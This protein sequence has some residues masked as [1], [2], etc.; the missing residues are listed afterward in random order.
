MKVSFYR[1]LLAAFAAASLTA[2]GAASAQV[3]ATKSTITATSKQMNVPVEGQFRKF[4]A[5]VAFDAAKPAAGSA[6]LTVDVGSYDLGDEGF[7][8]QV[9]G[10]DWFDAKTYPQATFVSSAIVPAGN[11]KYQVTGKLTIKG[12]SQT[13]VVPVTVGEQ[14]ATQT[15]DGTLPIKRLAFDIGTGEWKD[16]SV[17]DDQVLIKFHIVVA[18]H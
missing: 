2:A 11:N 6:Q 5:Q 16:T 18:K 15:F 9:A 13:V 4:S 1:Y 8:S 14:G 10:K 3:D 17:V 12:K 7:N